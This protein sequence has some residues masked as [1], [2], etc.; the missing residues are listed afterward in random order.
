VELNI[1][2]GYEA[3]EV[4]VE[5]LTFVKSSKRALEKQIR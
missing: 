5:R 2:E 3:Y 4:F 1:L